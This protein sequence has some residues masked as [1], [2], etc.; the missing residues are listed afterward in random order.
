MRTYRA[1]FLG[2]SEKF[3]IS[4]QLFPCLTRQML[5]FNRIV[6]IKRKRLCTM[7]GGLN[8]A[9]NKQLF[10]WASMT[11]KEFPTTVCNS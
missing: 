11:D 9:H 6:L 3:K 2:S 5:P 10:Y 7:A 1:T 4:T 8:M